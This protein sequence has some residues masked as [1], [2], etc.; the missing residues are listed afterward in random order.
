MRR[1][2]FITL[3]GSAAATWPLAARAQQPGQLPIIGYMGQGTPAAEAKRVAAFVERLRELS[4][5]EGRTV[6]IEYRWTDG[7]S[8]LA[9]D[10][11]AEFARRKVDTIV[12]SGTPLIAAKQATATIPIVFSAAGDPVGS[13]LVASLARPGGN[14]T[15]FLTF[16]YGL[17]A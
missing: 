16:E 4:W 9:A 12:T 6:V 11:A 3:L 7:R 2:E 5:I 13:G 15:G 1:R 17:S 14:V 8:D 10:I